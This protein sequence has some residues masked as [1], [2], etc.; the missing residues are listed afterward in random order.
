MRAACCI[1]FDASKVSDLSVAN[2]SH[3]GTVHSSREISD[4]A[5]QVTLCGEMPVGPFQNAPSRR[6]SMKRINLSRESFPELLEN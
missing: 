1:L 5:G 4:D 6:T 3:P 2:K